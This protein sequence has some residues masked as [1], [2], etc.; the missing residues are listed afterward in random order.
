MERMRERDREKRQREREEREAAAKA[1][2]PKLDEILSNQT[3]TTT[4]APAQSTGTTLWNKFLIARD[5]LTGGERWPDSDDSDYEGETHV[6]RVLREYA[7]KKAAA[8]VAAKIAELE[9]A[10]S[11]PTLSKAPSSGTRRNRYLQDAGQKENDSSRRDLASNND[12]YGQSLLVRGESGLR[13]SRSE[14]GPVAASEHG[15]IKSKSSSSVSRAGGDRLGNRFRTSSD[16]SLSEALGRLEGKRNQDAL[17]A[18]VSHLGS[19]RAR[20]PHRG[21]RAFKENIDEV[22]PPP[23]PT[24]KSNF[25]QQLQ[26]QRSFTRKLNDLGTYGERLQQ[27]QQQSR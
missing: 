23:L 15:I 13:P 18:Q 6:S 11:S 14:E 20:S 26:Q 12:Y 21:H 24:P 10:P 22:P 19:T 27:L 7:D 16:A 8:N 9:M 5:V 1:I 3:N 25:R 17:V 2:D 4:A